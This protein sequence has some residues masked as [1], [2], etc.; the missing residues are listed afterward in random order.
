MQIVAA[1]LRFVQIVF[2]AIVLGLSV[3]LAKGQAPS[4]FKK[5][6]PNA[7][8]D[9]P[10]VP[11][12]TAYSSFVGGFGMLVAL[13]GFASLFVELLQGIIMLVLDGLASIIFLAGG[14]AVAIG[15][16]GVS[17][18]TSDSGQLSMY[19]NSLVNTGCHGE[20][21]HL[22]CWVNYQ[23]FNN[24]SGAVDHLKGR[25]QM[26]EA[27]SAFMFLG[28]IICLGLLAHTFW[29]GGRTG[30]GKRATAV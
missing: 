13:I 27:D 25:C 1:I 17:C 23:Y 3:T 29:F 15:L 6:F 12:T 2:A 28:F 11:A 21:P 10:G 9:L 5:Q 30:M 24:D 7:G 20:V 22:Q 14:L 4:D 18:S 19:Q 26:D 16:R 8:Y